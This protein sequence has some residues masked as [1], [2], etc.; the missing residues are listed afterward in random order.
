MGGTKFKINI[1]SW[2]TRE[3]GFII[4]QIRLVNVHDSTRRCWIQHVLCSVAK[5]W[6]NQKQTKKLQCKIF[7]ILKIDQTR[8]K[9]SEISAINYPWWPAY[10]FLRS[11]KLVLF[12]YSSNFYFAEYGVKFWFEIYYQIEIPNF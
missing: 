2:T 7:F 12:N 3:L 8:T 4:K 9:I 10:A 6:I 11:Y 1:S 5:S